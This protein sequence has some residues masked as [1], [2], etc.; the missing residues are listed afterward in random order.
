MYGFKSLR[1]FIFKYLRNPISNGGGGGNNG[2]STSTCFYSSMMRRLH[3]FAG[4]IDLSILFDFMGWD[5]WYERKHTSIRR[6]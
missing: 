3:K 5:K 1:L 6:S 2:N 4:E